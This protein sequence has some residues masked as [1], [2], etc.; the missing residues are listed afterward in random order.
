MRIPS[1][2]MWFVLIASLILAGCGG[3]NNSVSP[4]VSD[5]IQIEFWHY[6]A[7]PHAK[8]IDDLLRRF[9]SD[10]PGIKVRAIYQGNPNQ[11]KQKLDGSFAS[12]TGNNPAVSLMYENWT[13][14]FIHRGYIEPVEQHFAGPDGLTTEEQQDF[15]RAFIQG[16]TWDGKLMT[17]PFNKSIYLLHMNMDALRNAGLTTAPKTQAEFQ[18]MVRQ[19]TIR[20]NGRTTMYGMGVQPKGEALTTLLLARGGELL[21]ANG[22]PRLNSDKALEVAQYL[23]NL[24]Y[25]DKHLYVNSDYMSQPLA[26]RLIACFIYSSSSLPFNETGAEGKFDY[27][28]APIPGVEGEEAR[29][30]MQGTN[31]GM[32]A[33]K[34]DHVKAAAWKLIKYLTR[35]DN[36]AYFVTRSGY[37]PYRYSMLEEPELKHYMASNPN[38]AMACQLVLADK[39]VQEP[40]VRAWEGVRLDIDNMVDQLLSRPDSDPRKLLDDL[41]RKAEQ[42]L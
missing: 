6:Q 7:G 15:V 35:P 26:S 36:A 42:K 12:G 29:Y 39:G 20:A 1:F 22:R 8:A 13:D 17:L 21:D 30:L 38:Y 24:Q 14:D 27:V 37:M 28:T 5:E 40:K 25:P 2:H 23:K 32:F 9:E 31:I 41:Q 10:N 34:P 16:N 18:D 11:L 33:N 3:G 4:G 19:T